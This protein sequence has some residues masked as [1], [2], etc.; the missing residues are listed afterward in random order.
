MILLSV[1]AIV[2]TMM[3]YVNGVRVT[4]DTKDGESG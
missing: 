4:I 1:L 3:I 2:L